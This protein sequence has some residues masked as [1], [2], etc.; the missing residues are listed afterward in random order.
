MT[1]E[2]SGSEAAAVP[3]VPPGY[4]A[5]AV[6]KRLLRSVRAG[7]LA[8]L[9]GD[10]TP[11]ATLIN[12]ATDFDGAPVLLMSGL[13]VHTRNLAAD[14]RAS[15]LLAE[16]GRGDPLAH[17]RLTVTGRVRRIDAVDERARLKLRFL[18][19]HPKSALYADFGDFAFYRLEITSVHLNGGFARAADFPG[20]AVLTPLAGAEALLEAETSAIEHMNADHAAAVRLYATKLC[21]EPDGRWRVTGIDPDGIDMAAGDMT[22]RLPFP[23]VVSDAAALRDSLVQLASAARAKE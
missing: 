16:G 21:G 12:V 7:A 11:F 18:A 17:P 5:I 20:E 14:P 23:R 9:T 19:R 10:G 2:A 13:A 15:I 3:G 22:A 4:D 6:S 1:T 8:T